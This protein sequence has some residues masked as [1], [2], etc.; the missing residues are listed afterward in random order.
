MP[1]SHATAAKLD[2]HAG[3]F[4]KCA[5]HPHEELKLF[6]ETRG[7]VCCTACNFATHKQCDVIYIPDAAKDYKTGPEY[8][9]LNDDVKEMKI[10][11]EKRLIDIDK[12][13]KAVE[14]QESDELEMLNIYRTEV[15]EFVEKRIKELSSQV[16]QIRSK[17]MTLLMEKHSKSQKIEAKLSSTQAKLKAC[18]HS[19]CKLFTESKQTL[20]FVAQLQSE[21]AGIADTTHYQH[22]EI[23]KD[24]NMEAVLGNKAGLATLE[25]IEGWL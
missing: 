24:T 22:I 8:I 18:E 23:R 13:M 1:T 21:L 16:K 6:C 10:L 15:I 3:T 19:P 4:Q 7:S 17:D 5:Q 9:K 20:S 14:K 12:S 2:S 11:A 25:L